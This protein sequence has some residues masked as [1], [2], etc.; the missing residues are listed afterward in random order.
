MANGSVWEYAT[1]A[2]RADRKQL[3]GP[4]GSNP[5]AVKVWDTGTGK[6]M[7]TLIG[8]TLPV[9]AVA[10]SPDGQRLAS[11]S[12]DR[13]AKDANRPPELF[14]WDVS[15][16]QRLYALP[17][18]APIFHLA[19]SPDGGQCVAAVADGMIW[20]WPTSSPQQ[21]R[22]LTGHSMAATCVAFSPDGKRLAS[23]SFDGMGKIW[24]PAAG[25]LLISFQGPQS[26]NT[27]TFGP[28]GRRL[29]GASRDMVKLWDAATGQEILTLRP[30]TAKRE[31]DF[32][33]LPKVAF[34]PDG[35][36]IAAN[37]HQG[38]SILVWDTK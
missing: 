30:L 32:A 2:F 14:V 8:H 38:D 18:N 25:K 37:F 28:D 4:S 9:I 34:S 26:L 20:L 23:V 36:R 29:A 15:S 5:R 13:G 17:T 3:A 10:L 27:V 6:E 21:R 31:R 24:D 33:F 12:W 22:M 7:Q 1:T 11:A 16:G 19:F 35:K